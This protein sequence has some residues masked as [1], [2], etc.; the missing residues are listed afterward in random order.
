MQHT[1][2][3]PHALAA[4]QLAA[5]DRPKRAHVNL[6]LRETRTPRSLYTLARLLRAAQLVD[7]MTEMDRQAALAA[8]LD[9]INAAHPAV[10]RKAA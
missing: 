7:E 8:R 9:A 1:I 3:H 4:V 10:L 6:A 2:S 5:I